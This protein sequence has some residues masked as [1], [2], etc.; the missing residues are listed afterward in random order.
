[1]N[2]LAAVVLNNIPAYM[3]GLGVAA[4]AAARVLARAGT[5]E[6]NAALLAAANDIEKN[7]VTILAA[8]A[9]DVVRARKA[10]FDA[11]FVDRLTLTEKSV[12]AMAAGLREVATLADPIGEIS[13]LKFRPSGIQVGKMR[14]SLGVI[15]MIYESRPNVTADAAALCLKSGNACILRGGSEALESNR[16]IY[17]CLVTGLRAASLPESS[18]QLIDT[19]DR[20]AVGEMLK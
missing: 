11:A 5:A 12:H 9:S 6:K 13:D 2:D 19:T 17:R 8:N 7:I 14:V 10:A 16:A 15:G 18:V 20:A 4:Q 1:M 3:H